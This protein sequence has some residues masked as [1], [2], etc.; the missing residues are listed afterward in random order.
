M[1]S[2][3]ET[4]KRVGYSRPY[5]ELEA[6]GGDGSDFEPNTSWNEVKARVLGWGF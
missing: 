3:I 2:K 1:W 4:R 6:M 5:L